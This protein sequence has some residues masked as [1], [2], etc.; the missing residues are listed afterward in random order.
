MVSSIQGKAA[1]NS[2]VLCPWNN[3]QK[4]EENM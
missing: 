3:K 4:A 1:G 2:Q